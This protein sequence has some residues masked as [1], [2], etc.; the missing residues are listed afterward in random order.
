[1][2]PPNPVWRSSHSSQISFIGLFRPVLVNDPDGQAVL[3]NC[4]FS[5]AWEFG[6]IYNGVF[7][8]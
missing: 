5:T 6:L 3:A 1:M 8:L 4:E 7:G 2:S